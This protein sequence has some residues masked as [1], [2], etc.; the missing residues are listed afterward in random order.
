MCSLL[1]KYSG[2]RLAAPPSPRCSA[3]GGGGMAFLPVRRFSDSVQSDMQTRAL[4][5]LSRVSKV[6]S[7]SAVSS[8]QIR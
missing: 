7:P 1:V 2:G 5:S 6:G 8:L 4:K 3:L